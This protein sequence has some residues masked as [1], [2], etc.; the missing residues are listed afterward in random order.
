MNSAVVLKGVSKQYDDFALR[1]I[2][3]HLPSG[4]VMGLVGV[5]GAGKSTLLRLLMGL[6]R[7]DGGEVEVL[8]QRLPQA[9]V[10]VKRDVGYASDDMRLYRGQ[11]LRW[12]M[13]FIARIYPGWD[14]NYAQD[15]LKRFNLK[16][17]QKLGGFSHGQRVKALLL[18]VF[19]RHP[20][21]L[22]LDEPTTG[23]DP[24]ARGEVLEALADVLRDEQRSVLFSSHN[25][26]DIEQIADSITFI[27]GGGIVASRDKESFLDSWRRILCQGQLSAEIRQLPGVASIRNSAPLIELK[28]SAFDAGTLP[29]LQSLGL[30]VKSVEPMS[31][32]DIFVTT[33]RGDNTP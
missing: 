17:Q 23:L 10:A 15:L 22:L 14:E 2:D 7:P 1:G 20:R 12:H 18:L 4:Q 28:T 21:L 31:L 11:S 19:T 30:T 32:E 33:V 16:S 6:I 3:L 29:V 5:N 9:Q 27:H 26:A 25:T 24:I 13:D 8:G